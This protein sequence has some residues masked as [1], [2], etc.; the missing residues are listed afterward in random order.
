MHLYIKELRKVPEK[1]WAAVVPL[2]GSNFTEVE[3][4]QAR[5]FPALTA[6]IRVDCNTGD[7][8]LV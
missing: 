6:Y 8:L 1:K 3:N 2:P 4:G 7:K 5:P